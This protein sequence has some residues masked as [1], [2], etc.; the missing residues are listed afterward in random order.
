MNDTVARRPGSVAKALMSALRGTA[1]ALYD[2]YRL[3]GRTVAVAPS[4]VAIAILPEL[5]QHVVEISLG[6]FQSVADFRAHAADPMRMAFG[7]VK[8][9]GFVV[10]ILLT[11]RFWA[12]GS[13]RAALLIRPASLVRLGWA[14]ALT[15]AVAFAFDWLVKRAPTVAFPLQIVSFLT[16]AGLTLYVVAA[17]LDDRAMTLRRVFTERWPSAV[18]MTLL[19]IA[20]FGP[21]Q[22]LHMANHKLVIGQAAPIVW[23]VMTFDGLF[24]GLF[25]AL[26]GSALYVGYRTGASW[27]GWAGEGVPATL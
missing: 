12:R 20:A 3:G 2:T 14:I 11:A 24:V 4:I 21:A 5:A 19:L 26:V 16:Q 22:A 27:R 13:V 7:Y 1:R 10:A 23:A 8:I 17:L 6:M 15:L 25:A 9:A 18:V